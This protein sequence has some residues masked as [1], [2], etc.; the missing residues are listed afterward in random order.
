MQK[1]LQ[2]TSPA[3]RTS[4]SSVTL[5]SVRSAPIQLDLEMLKH[6]SGGLAPNGTWGPE[7]CGAAQAPNGTW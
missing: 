4:K 1:N 2:S 6:V 7:S 3:Q 5:S